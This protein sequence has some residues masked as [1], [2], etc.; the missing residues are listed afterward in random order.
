MIAADL[1]GVGLTAGAGRQLFANRRLL[2][3]FIESVS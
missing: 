2:H 1:A 3:R